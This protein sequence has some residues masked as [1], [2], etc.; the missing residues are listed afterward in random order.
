[1]SPRS[2]AENAARTKARI[3]HAAVNRAS[4]LGLESISV[5]ELASDLRMSKSGV[6]GPFKSRADLLAAALDLAIATFQSTVIEP[7]MRIPAGTSRMTDLVERWIDYLTQ[8]PF[9]GGCFITAASIELDSRP[10]RLRDRIAQTVGR[11]HE[12]LTREVHAL[13]PSQPV[14]RAR[15]V[16]TTLIGISM[17]TNQELQL[18]ADPTAGPRAKHAMQTAVTAFSLIQSTAADAKTT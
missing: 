6:I 7:T 12:F 13:N 4:A 17:A 16:A 14:E 18:L 5:R 3:V 2:S 9:P 11:W 8:C 10:G 15:E 1:M